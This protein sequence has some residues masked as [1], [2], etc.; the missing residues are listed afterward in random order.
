MPP[1]RLHGK[2]VLC[3]AT[4]L[5]GEAVAPIAD[6]IDSINTLAD[7]RALTALVMAGSVAQ[8]KLN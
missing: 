3:A 7:V 1:D 8:E 4:V 5:R 2:F 6:A